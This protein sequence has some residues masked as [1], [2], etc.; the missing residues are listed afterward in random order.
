MTF[1]GAKLDFRVY[2]STDGK[3]ERY[4]VEYSSF[5]DDISTFWEGT[6]DRALTRLNNQDVAD[7]EEADPKYWEPVWFE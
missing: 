1:T 2:F 3:A 6:P 4:T 7:P 5:M